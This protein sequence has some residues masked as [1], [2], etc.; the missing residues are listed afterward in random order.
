LLYVIRVVLRITLNQLAKFV[1]QYK[2][3]GWKT[4]FFFSVFV[5]YF[6]MLYGAKFQ[7][8]AKLIRIYELKDL[9]EKNQ[10]N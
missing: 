5:P 9:I 7:A 4:L 10:K 6:K 8:I 3:S 2:L 1:I